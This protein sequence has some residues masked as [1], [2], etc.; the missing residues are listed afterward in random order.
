MMS[1]QKE[2]LD[3]PYL[4]VLKLAPNLPM[5]LK[6]S[7][8]H[9]PRQPC[10]SVIWKTLAALAAMARARARLAGNGRDHLGGRTAQQERA[11]VAVLR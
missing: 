5:I 4:T 11:D 6:G 3:S 2:H 7:T 1:V 9:P 10:V 8:M